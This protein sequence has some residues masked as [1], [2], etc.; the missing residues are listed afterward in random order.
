MNPQTHHAAFLSRAHTRFIGSKISAFERTFL[1]R[2]ERV[3]VGFPARFLGY[4]G[5]PV[6]VAKVAR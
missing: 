3:N 2:E 4:S 5:G 1:A 6:W